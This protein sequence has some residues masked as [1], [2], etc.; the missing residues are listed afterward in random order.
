MEMRKIYI[1]SL[2][3]IALT[4][5]SCS[6]SFLDVPVQ[7]GVTVDTDPNL[8]SKLVTG[9]Y[10]NLTQGDSWGN[11]DVHGFAFI[12]V[13]NIM[14]DDADKGST[15]SDQLVP[16]GDLDNFHQTSTNK[17]AET[18]W[19]GHY[20][21]IGSCNQAL[22]ALDASTTLTDAAKKNS[23]GGEVR[24]VRAYLYFNLVRMYGKVP[25]VLAIPADAAAA[26]TDPALRTRAAVTDVYNAIIADL[27]FAIQNL[28]LKSASQVG[29]AN[30]GAAQSML[31]KVYLYLQ[32]WQK[33]YDLTE[34]VIA[35]NQY[36]L[37]PDY[38]EL[39]RQAND[40][41]DESVWEIGTGKFNNANEKIDNYTVCQGPR[42]GGAG[43]WDDLG[44]GF[45]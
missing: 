36:S 35:S 25:L 31:A 15:A 28:P 23:L 42:V 10:N 32:N 43:G 40:F 3:F 19:G 37:L 9:V 12:S 27:E 5:A 1:A 14:S 24:F 2:T 16:V 45:N 6:D 38:A 26:N 30:Q 41:S 34:A 4:I 33:A 13:T 8:A 11:G 29:H 44:W 7:G 22:K 39:W 21:A 18:L 17:F 20:K